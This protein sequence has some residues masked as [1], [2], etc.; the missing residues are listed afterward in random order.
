MT[1]FWVWLATLSYAGYS[2]VAP[3]TAG[4]LVTVVL[5]YLVKPYWA[6][7]VFAQVGAIV[8]VFFLGIPASKGAIRHFGRGDPGQCVIDEMAGQMIALLLL[9]HN[10]YFY[11]GGFGL[12]RLFDIWKPVPVKTAERVPGAWG[13]MLDDVVAGLYA[14]I[15]M[16]VYLRLI[17]PALFH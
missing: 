6:A 3:G 11:L 5:V 9:P 1:R 15:I 7:P 8:I 16:Q 17:H 14:L 4:S 13:I 10:I 2:P 12:F